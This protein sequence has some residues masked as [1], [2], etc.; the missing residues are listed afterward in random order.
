MKTIHSR[1]RTAP[2]TTAFASLHGAGSR[3]EADAASVE[4]MRAGTSPGD[5]EVAAFWNSELLDR[6]QEPLTRYHEYIFLQ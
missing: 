3:D 1:F 5:D 4:G 6:L 2:F